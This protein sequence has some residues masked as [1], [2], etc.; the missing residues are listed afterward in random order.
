[1]SISY[2]QQE[3]G[4][5]TDFRDPGEECEECHHL[6]ELTVAEDTGRELCEYCLADAQDANDA[7]TASF[8]VARKAYLTARANAKDGDR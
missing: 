2:T 4:D 7:A 6:H 3:S 1:M 5:Q 8:K